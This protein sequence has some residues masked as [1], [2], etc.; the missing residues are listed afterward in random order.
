MQ[1]RLSY[2][3]ISG[4]KELFLTEVLTH[5]ASNERV[6]QAPEHSDKSEDKYF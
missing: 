4:T 2:V 5:C 1:Q 3:K 6:M